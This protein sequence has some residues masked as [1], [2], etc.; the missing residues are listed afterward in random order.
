MN[1][2]SLCFVEQSSEE[3]ECFDGMNRSDAETY[4]IVTWWL[5]GVLHITICCLG[6][7]SNLVSMRVLLSNEM[8][9]VFNITLAILAFFDAVY[10]LCD[11]L[12]SFRIVH[13]NTNPCLELPF[14]QRLHLY[15]F[16]HVLR[17]MG[18]ISMVASIYLTIIVATER[19]FAVSKPISSFV[20]YFEGH[21][22]WKSALIYTIPVAIFSLVFSMPKF[23]EF[24]VNTFEF[25]CYK[26]VPIE[27]LD[28]TTSHG[29]LLM[30]QHGTFYRIY[31][32]S[33]NKSIVTANVRAIRETPD[34][35]YYHYF[36]KMFINQCQNSMTRYLG[37]A[38]C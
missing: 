9:N 11:V 26:D 2:S 20:G 36:P 6:F 37:Y 23:F 25:L 19:Y 31:N 35:Y 4:T 22:K 1:N 10:T 30:A 28:E 17:P 27:K 15:V 18:F 24:T 3:L 8:K 5:E 14:Y 13:Y 29:A 21:G 32:L 34:L 12:E 38:Y 7:V 16:P 33:C